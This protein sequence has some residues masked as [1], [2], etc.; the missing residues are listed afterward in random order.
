MTVIWAVLSHI[1]SLTCFL[2]VCYPELVFL[3]ED[4]TS[5]TIITILTYT[6][7]QSVYYTRKNYSNLSVC[8]YLSLLSPN[9]FLSCMTHSTTRLY[10]QFIA[11]SGMNSRWSLLSMC[12]LIYPNCTAVVNVSK[13]RGLKRFKTR[14]VSKLP[15]HIIVLHFINSYFTIR[16]S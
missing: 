5:C 13:R 11:A 1:N 2:I 16:A 7:K 3:V 14:F 15:C 10:S 4:R 6:S 8:I 12:E 9:R